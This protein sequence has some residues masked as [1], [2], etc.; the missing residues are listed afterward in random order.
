MF[1]AMLY[2]S[3]YT[4][5]A[6]GLWNGTVVP[7]A[8]GKVGPYL[9]PNE[10]DEKSAKRGKSRSTAQAKLLNKGA[11]IDL[12]RSWLESE[13][14]ESSSC[15]IHLGTDQVRNMAQQYL[16]KWNKSAGRPKKMIGGND[17][18]VLLSA[19]RDLGD[20][21][22]KLDDLADCLMQGLAFVRWEENKKLLLERGVEAF[23]LSLE[24][25]TNKDPTPV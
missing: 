13:R 21:P 20:G 14:L 7:I 23:D 19:A 17:L 18:N 5:Y 9:L 6:E 15:P 16:E 22:S 11:K 25:A 1:E 2:S 3:L 8:P 4:M 24:P 10:E 12:V